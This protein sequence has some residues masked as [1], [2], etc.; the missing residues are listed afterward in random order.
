MQFHVSPML[1]CSASASKGAQK[2]ERPQARHASRAEVAR[3]RDIDVQMMGKAMPGGVHEG[4]F[5]SMGVALPAC[6]ER[7][8][9]DAGS[10]ENTRDLSE[11]KAKRGGT[12][13]P[14]MEPSASIP[15]KALASSANSKTVAVLYFTTCGPGYGGVNRHRALAITNYYHFAMRTSPQSI[16]PSLGSS[17]A[18]AAMSADAT[19][20]GARTT[21]TR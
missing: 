12:Q 1:R 7:S 17:A 19:T 10:G 2:S 18:T 16:G 11:R 15:R 4:R 8:G 3:S 6:A 21:A 14:G 5:T 9:R 13:K 20:T